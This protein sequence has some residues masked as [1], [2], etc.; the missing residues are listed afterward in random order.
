MDKPGTGQSFTIPLFH[1]SF[2]LLLLITFFSGIIPMPHN[3]P[4]QDPTVYR[5]DPTSVKI[6]WGFKS[7]PCTVKIFQGPTPEK[8]DRNRPVAVTTS[9]DHIVIDHLECDR[10]YYFA[11]A[12]GSASELMTS[13]RRMPLEG[14]VNF[15]DLGGYQTTGG[16]T[17][18]WGHI[19][20]SDK[21]AGLSE[22]DLRLLSHLNIATIC[23]FRTAA[24]TRKAPGRHPESDN[25]QYLHFP[26][27]HGEHDPAGAFERIKKG[28]YQWLNEAF[29]AKGYILSIENF[30]SLWHDFFNVLANRD[31]RP[32]VFHCTGGKDRTGTAAAL[33]LSVLGVP[34]KTIVED[35]AISAEY[36]A[37]V[38]KMINSLLE[39]MGVD[40]EEVSPYFTVTP[41]RM[42][43]LLEHIRTTYGSAVNYLVNKAG[44]DPAVI[45]ELKR[46]LLVDA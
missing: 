42:Q 26:I 27:Q 38:L 10:P 19:F 8:I 14:A 6:S 37:G 30:A 16:K 22:Q 5:L 45:A 1:F 13:E 33:I 3:H 28:D 41:G 4:L 43:A 40:P 23:D 18:R 9:E 21:L 29:M 15:R 12:T 35:Y 20:R 25:L 31:R 11:L 46:D 32:F 44:L 17:V 34:D 36:I 24:E 7:D 2:E 39:E